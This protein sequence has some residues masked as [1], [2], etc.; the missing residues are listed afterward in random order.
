MSNHLKTGNAQEVAK[1]L[2]TCDRVV[3][4]TYNNV[5]LEWGTED[6]YEVHMLEYR[7]KRDSMINGVA[8][9]NLLMKCQLNAFRAGWY[10]TNL[11]ENMHGY[12]VTCHVA[13]NIQGGRASIAGRG[14]TLEQAIRNGI[15]RV[16]ERGDGCTFQ[17][18]VATLPD[19]VRNALVDEAPE[20]YSAIVEAA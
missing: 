12:T 14:L 6:L 3:S 9:R 2:A 11:S 7:E 4:G 5:Y 20:T 17:V 1:L 8:R 10:P 18:T 16:K 13:S 15:E 19:E